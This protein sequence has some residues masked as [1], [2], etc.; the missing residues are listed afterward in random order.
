MI[1][2]DS[3]ETY[4]VITFA[5]GGEIV[6]TRKRVLDLYT[7]ACGKNFLLSTVDGELNLRASE[8]RSRARFRPQ[9]E[10]IRLERV[11]DRFGGLQELE[12]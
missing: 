3:E 10:G 6:D 4:A 12:T 5:R 1:P 11:E 2:L 8:D 7:L 9:L